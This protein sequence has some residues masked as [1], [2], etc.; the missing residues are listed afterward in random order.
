MDKVKIIDKAIVIVLFLIY[1]YLMIKVFILKNG[2]SINISRLLI[3]ESFTQKIAGANFIP[4]RTIL[5][6]LSGKQGLSVAAR[7]LLGN[8]IAF[9]PLGF[10]LPVLFKRLKNMKYTLLIS[11]LV[12][13]SIETIQ[14]FTCI[15][16][17]DID[18]IILN[19]LGAT[20][21][22]LIYK[23]FYSYIYDI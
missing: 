5:Y 10:S 1:I 12:T 2:L 22:F 20:I 13:F 23:K 7:N 16:S 17:C 6:Y 15:G 8:I 18:D 4:F 21:G 3:H 11:F 19:V 14:L 9:V